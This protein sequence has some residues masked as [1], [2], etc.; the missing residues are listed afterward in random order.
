MTVASARRVAAAALAAGL[1][2]VFL[3]QTGVTLAKWY[4]ESALPGTHDI[5]TGSLTLTAGESN[6]V[7]LHS[8]FSPSERTFTGGTACAVPE[9]FAACREL[10]IAELAD[11]L[12]LPGDQLLIQET[13][14]ASGDGTNLVA[15]VQIDRSDAAGS[16]P[17]GTTSSSEFL[18]EGQPVT[19]PVEI[20]GTDPAE[21]KD[22]EW[23]VRTKLTT[24]EE[25]PASFG[26]SSIDLGALTISI[27]QV[28][29]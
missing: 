19:A 14:H 3:S 5:T 8:R 7:Q 27:R 23:L 25:W 13:F 12:L 10:T 17:A 18:R 1:G 15:E 6:P 16:L 2:L 11:Q 29:P 9:G 20:S 22:A 28:A 4:E 21:V 26:T 24:P